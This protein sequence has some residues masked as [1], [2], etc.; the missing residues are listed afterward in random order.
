MPTPRTVTETLS[1]GHMILT[2]LVCKGDLF[3]LQLFE[4]IRLLKK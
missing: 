3:A 2:L 1:K 4:N